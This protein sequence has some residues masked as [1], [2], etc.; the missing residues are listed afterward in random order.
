MDFP[1]GGLIGDKW[2]ATGRVFGAATSAGYPFSDQAGRRQD[3]V[4][5]SILWSRSLAPRSC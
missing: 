5:G 4:N 1:I 2:A 3:F